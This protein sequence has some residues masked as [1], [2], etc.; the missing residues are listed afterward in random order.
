M[1]IAIITILGVLV[2]ALF[3]HAEYQKR[4]T[5]AVILKG[6]ASAM[7]CT[8][9]LLALNVC[10]NLP[11]AKLICIG[12]GFGALGDILLNL[13]FVFPK[14]GQLI[15][16]VGIVA[17]LTGHVLYLAALIPLS[18]SLLISLAAGVLAGAALLSWI[19]KTTASKPAFRVFGTFYIGSI[20]LMTAVAIG[21]VV[22]GPTTAAI[23]HAVGAVLFTLSDIVLILNTF[24]GGTPKFSLRITN[25]TLYYLGQLFIAFS[26]YFI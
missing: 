10:Q 5:K 8:I 25:L 11:F 3:I 20:V 26:L 14:K 19:F 17:F 15:F 22:T 9:G 21:N 23:M 4:Y 24:G 13:R 2:Q 16:L 7:F 18:S 12:L 6:F 1:T